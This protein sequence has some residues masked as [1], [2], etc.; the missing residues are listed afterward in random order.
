MGR[1]NPT[2]Y[3]E[4]TRRSYQTVNISTYKATDWLNNVDV[5]V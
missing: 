1:A 3:A 2:Y 5:N 4:R